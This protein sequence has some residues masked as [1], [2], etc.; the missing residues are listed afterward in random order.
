MFASKS[1]DVVHISVREGSAMTHDAWTVLF[2]LIAG[3]STGYSM[4]LRASNR[5]YRKY[6]DKAGASCDEASR[7]ITK[8]RNRIQARRILEMKTA[9]NAMRKLST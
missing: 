2:A 1:N 5:D 8:L 9:A 4:G 3:L 6:I 7:I